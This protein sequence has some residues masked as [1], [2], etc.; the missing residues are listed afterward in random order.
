M[1]LASPDCAL[2]QQRWLAALGAA[3]L[4]GLSLAVQGRGHGR[5]PVAAEPFTG[6]LNAIARIVLEQWL[7]FPRFVLSGAWMRALQMRSTPQGVTN[8]G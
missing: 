5:E 8:H 6:P 4:T 1:N 2:L 3:A 7:T